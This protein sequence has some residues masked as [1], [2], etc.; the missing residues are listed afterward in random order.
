MEMVEIIREEVLKVMD[1]PDFREI[2]SIGDMKLI[3]DQKIPVDLTNRPATVTFS[4]R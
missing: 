3:A 2:M 1:H 4:V